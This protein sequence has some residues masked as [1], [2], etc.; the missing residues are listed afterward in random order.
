MGLIELAETIR[1]I[2]QRYNVRFELYESGAIKITPI[3]SNATVEAAVLFN[4]HEAAMRLVLT[5]GCDRG[6]RRRT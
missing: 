2:E 3:V 1:A 5:F 4:E 6:D